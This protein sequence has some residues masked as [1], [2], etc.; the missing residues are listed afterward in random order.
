M[1]D[2]DSVNALTIRNLIARIPNRLDNRRWADLRTLFADDV[3]TDYLS[4][5]GGEVQRQPAA[6]LVAGWQRLLSPL[7]ATQHII[8]AIDV[9]LLGDHA[10][11]ECHVRA[12]HVR[13]DAPGGAEWMIAGHYVIELA[14]VG[15]A[16]LIT[17]LTLLTFYQTGNRNLLS[18]AG[19]R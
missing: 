6:D 8:G 11:A 15:A 9:H 7:D 5:F 16:W 19:G 13:H 4:L 3:T 1:M 18:Q 2:N 12:Y 10:R 14:I 17:S